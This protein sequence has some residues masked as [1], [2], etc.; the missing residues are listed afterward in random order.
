MPLTLYNTM[1]RRKEEFV[2]QEPGKVGMYCCGL[3]VYNYAHIGNLRTYIFEDVL[4][5]AIKFEGYALLHVQNIT[6]VGHMTSDA[7]SGEDKMQTAAQRENK[8]PWEIARFYEQAALFD[9]ERLNIQRPEIMPRA[10][11]HI[12][13]MIALIQRLE[14][15]GMTYV[16]SEGVYFDTS[17]D[18]DYGK[19]ARLNLAQQRQGAREEVITDETKRN[20][21]DF[22]LWFVN[23]PTHIMQWE[24]PWGRGYPGWHIECSAMS[25]K[26]LGET[27]DI[28]CGGVDHIPVHHTNEIAQSEC[29]THHPFVRTWLHGEF[30]QM[31]NQKISKSKG[32]SIN[33]LQSLIDAGYDPLAYRYFCLQAHYR[34]ELN[35]SPEAL[36][37][38]TAG[39][40]KVYA[41]CP[42]SDPLK[43]DEAAYQ[44][45]RQRVLGAIE[46]DLGMPQAVGLLNAYGSYRL[47]VEFDAILGLEIASRSC[48]GE[49]TLPAEIEALAQERDAAR[50]AK[51]WAR[52]DALRA[53]LI[54]MGYDV[55]DSPQGTTVKR[56]AL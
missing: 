54:E 46:D 18:P 8:S 52:S 7:D 11:E 1:T 41:L 27:F 55:G 23:K 28:H 17:R 6:D 9:F 56:R 31:N 5:R 26:Y 39:L 44:A 32:G 25:M 51:D 49:D 19:L 22:V 38:A 40:R 3:T 42:D 53:Q 43:D 33:T 45:A 36:E 35:F 20:P 12:A 13:E 34:S 4:R 30:L 10:T 50:K 47:W 2:P 16:T 24:S 29:A 37:A 21:S 14:K 48:Q 15:N